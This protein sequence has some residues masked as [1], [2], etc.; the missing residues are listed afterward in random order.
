[1]TGKKLSVRVSLPASEKGV[2]AA[3]P[4]PVILTQSGY[5]TNL[6]SLLFLGAPGNLM[7][8]TPDYL[9]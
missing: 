1:S 3:G 6:L 8:G 4:F 9:W 2:P 5:N 7:L